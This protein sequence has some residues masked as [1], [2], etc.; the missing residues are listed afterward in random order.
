MLYEVITELDGTRI[1]RGRLDDVR[2]EPL[3]L[4]RQRKSVTIS[5]LKS[6]LYE[7]QK[8]L[9]QGVPLAERLSQLERLSRLERQAPGQGLDQAQLS[10]L[11][12]ELKALDLRLYR[13]QQAAR[14]PG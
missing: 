1:G 2:D 3:E 14:Q 11:A 10:A 8:S 12:D 13:L 9:I 7:I 4:E 5:Y 6:Q